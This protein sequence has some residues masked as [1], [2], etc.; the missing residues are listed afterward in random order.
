MAATPDVAMS[1]LPP[2]LPWL[3]SG[4]ALVA[5]A[6]A[7]AWIGGPGRGEGPARGLLLAAVAVIVIGLAQRWLRLG[8]GPFLNLFEIL[9]SS[10][11]SL[12][13]VLCWAGRRSAVLRRCQPVALGLL[14]LLAAWLLVVPPVDSHLPP[15]YQTPV[16]WFHVGLGKVFLGVAL[17]ALGVAGALLLRPRLA[18]RFAGLPDDAVLDA[19]AWRLMAVALLFETLML[20]AGAVWAQD[21]W[22]RWWAWDPL[23]TW[24]FLTWLALVAALHARRTWAVAPRWGAWLI[25]AVFMLAF[26]TFFGVPFVS[27]A[28]HKGAV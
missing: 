12:G 26:F 27:T 18:Q 25:V 9:A 15:T 3:W 20:V 1:A 16:L 11:A 21:A 13:A 19:L 4:C 5:G 6:T 14:S 28:P 17:A 8:H 23:E 7:R 22:G 2:E 10:L 24:A